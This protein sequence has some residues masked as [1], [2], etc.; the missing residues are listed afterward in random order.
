LSGLMAGYTKVSFAKERC[1][2]EDDSKTL[3]DILVKVTGRTVIF[4]DIE[5]YYI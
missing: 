5:L 3:L 1:T 4:F 2:E